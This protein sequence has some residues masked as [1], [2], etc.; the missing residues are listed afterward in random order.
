[1]IFF[2]LY[3][4]V[5]VSSKYTVSLLLFFI[6][7]AKGFKKYTLFIHRNI[8]ADI[9]SDI[10]MKWYIYYFYLCAISQNVQLIHFDTRMLW[11]AASSLDHMCNKD[12][13]L[14][15][16]ITWLILIFPTSVIFGSP[17]SILVSKRFSCTFC[18]LV[19]RKISVCS[20]GFSSLHTFF[21]SYG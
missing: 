5:S 20:C 2:R 12:T 13:F 15:T 7:L 1:M 16:C 9:K 3:L 14:T 19:S 18:E 11:L 17:Y 8:F 21:L 4:C 6:F 10:A